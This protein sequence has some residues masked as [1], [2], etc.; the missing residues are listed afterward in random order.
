MRFRWLLL[1]SISGLDLD[2]GGRTEEFIAS[3]SPP[4]PHHIPQLLGV[5]WEEEPRSLGTPR[6]SGAAHI[7]CRSNGR[8]VI[9]GLAFFSQL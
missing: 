9:E 4:F 8:R 6:P 2:L 5:L 3:S 1:P 7:Q